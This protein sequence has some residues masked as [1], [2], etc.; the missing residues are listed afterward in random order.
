[1]IRGLDS[2]I[3]SPPEVPDCEEEAEDLKAMIARIDPTLTLE[4]WAVEL[5]DAFEH[6]LQI[7]VEINGEMIYTDFLPG[8]T[9]DQVIN[10]EE[11]VGKVTVSCS[12]VG[13][14]IELGPHDLTN[15]TYDS[16]MT[17][18]KDEA[19]FYWSRD[20]CEHY[21]LKY[22]DNTPYI[23][24]VK[25]WEDTIGWEGRKPPHKVKK[26]VEALPDLC[27]AFRKWWVIESYDV[28]DWVY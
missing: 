10:D 13:S 3:E 22:K 8:R 1:M 2:W 12:I 24:R 14:D 18:L 6:S 11:L 5:Y 23:F 17:D 21:T 26:M 4:E 20:N 28:G 19:D 25:N 15:D 7:G 9:V 16:V 27:V